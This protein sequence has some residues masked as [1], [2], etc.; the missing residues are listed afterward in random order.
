[1]S[2]GKIYA[3]CLGVYLLFGVVLFIAMEVFAR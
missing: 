1:M 3:I 2:A